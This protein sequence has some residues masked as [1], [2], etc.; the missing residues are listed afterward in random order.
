MN[1]LGE[2]F[3]DIFDVAVNKEGDKAQ[4]VEKS[5]GNIPILDIKAIRKELFKFHCGKFK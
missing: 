1:C 2:I 3:G 4:S 5:K